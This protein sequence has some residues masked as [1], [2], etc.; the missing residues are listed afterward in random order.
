MRN[1]GV[2]NARYQEGG[3]CLPSTHFRLKGASTTQKRQGRRVLPL[4]P[5]TSVLLPTRGARV[6][7]RAMQQ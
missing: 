6:K 1:T 3:E 2:C 5:V 7:L 4:N